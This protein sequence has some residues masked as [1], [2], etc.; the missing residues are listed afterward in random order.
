MTQNLTHKVEEERLKFFFEKDYQN[1]NN[2]INE[3]ASEFEDMDDEG[4]VS[5][6]EKKAEVL[7]Q[8]ESAFK[9]KEF[10]NVDESIKRYFKDN[11]KRYN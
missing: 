5:I 10:F 11:K 8:I 1:F 2:L 3:F 6:N 4:K 9:K 7:T